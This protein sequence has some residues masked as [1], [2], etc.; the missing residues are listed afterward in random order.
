M[1][2][3]VLNYEY[4]PLGGGAGVVTQN[5]SERL[6]LLGHKVTVVTTW[7]KTEKE[8]EETGNLK[9]VRL[10]SKRI[11]TYKSSVPEM[12]SWIKE[13]RKFLQDYCRKEKFD[14]CLLILQYQVVL[15]LY[16]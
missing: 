1:N 16:F 13:S 12:L 11:H 7:F 6:A 8:T 2:L 15:S 9:I 5:I 4:P 3:L 10:K 14:L